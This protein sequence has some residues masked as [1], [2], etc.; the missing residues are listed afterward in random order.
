MPYLFNSNKKTF[1]LHSFKVGRGCN[2]STAYGKNNVLLNKYKRTRA[3]R[4][5]HKQQSPINK[6]TPQDRAFLKSIGLK[7][8][9]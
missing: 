3:K 4:K 7:V 5:S 8:L 9:K 1:N 2:I 6:L